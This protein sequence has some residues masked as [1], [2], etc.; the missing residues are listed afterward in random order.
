MDQQASDGLRR[1][2][3]LRSGTPE[4]Q[5]NLAAVNDAPSAMHSLNDDQQGPLLQFQ[6][7]ILIT[8]DTQQLLQPV[9]EAGDDPLLHAAGPNSEM[10]QQCGTCLSCRQP[11]LGQVC[12]CRIKAA[13]FASASRIAFCFYPQ[14]M[15]PAYSP[16]K[17]PGD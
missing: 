1:S 10:R 2:K 5:T 7:R 8:Q 4:I 13:F 15:K 3:R 6:E 12:A 14:P 16:P 9:V 17:R 11:W